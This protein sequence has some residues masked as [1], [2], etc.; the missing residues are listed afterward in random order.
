MKALTGALRSV[1]RRRTNTRSEVQPSLGS[2]GKFLWGKPVARL[3]S[4]TVL[5][6]TTTAVVFLYER[7]TFSVLILL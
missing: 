3:L 5:L 1:Y 6:Q 7:D 4:H 2:R